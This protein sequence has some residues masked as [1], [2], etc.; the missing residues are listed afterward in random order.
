MG[1]LLGLLASCGVLV[2]LADAVKRGRAVRAA[3]PQVEGEVRVEDLHDPARILRDARGVAHVRAGSERDAYLALGLVHAQDRLGQMVWLRRSAQGRLAEVLGPEALA[4]DREAR[5]LGIARH[6]ERALQELP[7]RSRGLL[8]AY[9]Q[10]V[11]SW[12]GRID[13]GDAAPPVDLARGH[14]PI[15]AWRPEDSLALVKLYS[16]SLG[17]TLDTAVVLQD[18]IQQL[19][20]FG[21]QPFFPP[22]VGP[23]TLPDLGRSAR[24]RES[25]AR[26]S[27]PPLGRPVGLTEFAGL[28]GRSLGSAAFVVAGHETK[29]GLPLLVAD[30]HL[31]TQAPALLYQAHLRWR[32]GQVAGAGIPGVPVF[33]TGHNG[34]VA[35]A[36]VNAGAVVADF[37]VETLHPSSERYHDGRGWREFSER[38]ESIEVRGDEVQELRVRE[39]RHGP[40][41][42]EVLAGER[43][44]LSLAW[45]GARAG[46]SVS[47]FLAVA[48]A[49]DADALRRALASHHEPVLSVAYADRAGAAGIQL[50]GWLPSRSLPTGLVPVPGRNRWYAWR[51]G[52]DYDAMP[53]T[54]LS[55][56]SP[57]AVAADEQQ[58]VRA[59]AGVVEWLWRTGTRQSRLRQ[60]LEAAVAQGPLDLRS[61]VAFSRD[62]ESPR[63]RAVL[64]EALELV[65]PLAELGTEERWVAKR[66]RDWDGRSAPESVGATL[67][68]VFLKHL[69]DALLEA[70]LGEDMAR[71]YLSLQHVD[72]VFL[73][74]RLLR[75]SSELAGLR[76]GGST[77][78][79]SLRDT[80]IWLSVELGPNHDR[81]HWGRLHRLSFR[82]LWRRGPWARDLLGPFATGGDGS[83]VFT[84]EFDPS[85]GFEVRLASLFR[86]GLDLAHPGEALTTLAPGQSGHPG[87]P[88][89]TDGVADWRSGRP[90]LLATSPILVDEMAVAELR[91]EPGS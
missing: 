53:H 20:G 78:K 13:A 43:E 42:N 12:L 10:G 11:N 68:H 14:V 3:F 89:S 70:S 35:W 33:W 22:G 9:A 55:A 21:A 76:P 86:F 57:F 16:W 23:E 30:A 8:E 87:H 40:L 74:E 69:L 44:P 1:I 48:R 15:E 17:R 77:V 38:S 32:D 5:L 7:K 45:S 65:G 46:D 60:L 2:L 90:R 24:A 50:A 39:T 26:L 28:V 75:P 62:V 36:G 83:T 27:P 58:T 56:G 37:F 29:N 72:S 82:P 71:R 59:G 47:A 41:V 25:P 91:L 19:G 67:Y 84:A 4:A 81:W 52:V 18:L 80:W 73:A 66:L 63:Q 54:E 64:R 34:R 79:R 61:A 49:G 6:A 31:P 51:E 85:R 88:H